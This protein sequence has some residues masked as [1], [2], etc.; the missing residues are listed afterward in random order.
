[1]LQGKNLGNAK[2][3]DPGGL[4]VIPSKAQSKRL[5]EVRLNKIK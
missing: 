2:P 4:A 3:A 1:M 5:T